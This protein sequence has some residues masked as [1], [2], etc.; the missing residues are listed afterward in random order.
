MK[1]L[2]ILLLKCPHI[3]AVLAKKGKN[4]YSI[5]IAIISE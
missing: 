3:A 4:G 5:D 2:Y 1:L